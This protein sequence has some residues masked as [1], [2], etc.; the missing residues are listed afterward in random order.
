MDD[1]WS[2]VDETAADTVA[3]WRACLLVDKFWFDVDKTAADA[4]VVWRARLVVGDDEE[5][6]W[7]D[8]LRSAVRA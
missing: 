1:R 3:V 8:W 7:L 2:D 5:E 4:V 6:L